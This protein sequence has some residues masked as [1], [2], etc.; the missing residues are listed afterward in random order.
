ME[1]YN[2]VVIGAGSGGLVVAA[3]ATGLG[4]R[5]A[6]AEKHRRGATA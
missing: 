1:R 5:V 2:I 4:A 6:L 3:G